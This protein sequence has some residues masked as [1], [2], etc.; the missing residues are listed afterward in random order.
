M[1]KKLIMRGGLGL[2]SNILALEKYEIVRQPRVFK[3][4]H[5]KNVYLWTLDFYKEADLKRWEKEFGE[6]GKL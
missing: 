2:F 6:W 4:F 5:V 3:L 1:Q